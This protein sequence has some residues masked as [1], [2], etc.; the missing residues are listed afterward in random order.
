MDRSIPESASEE[1]ELYMRTYYSLLR[2]SGEIQIKS[3]IET[4]AQ[5]DSSLHL[6]AREDQPDIAAFVYCTLRLP[7]CIDRVRLVLLGQSDEV[8]VKA[9]FADVSKWQEVSA[10]GRRRKLFFDGTDVL[11]AFIASAS[12]IDDLI[13]ILTAH[14]IEWNKIHDLL[15][16][17]GGAVR[18]A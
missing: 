2:S 7:S 10:A 9:G 3:L 15:T 1:I 11:A 13:P 14:E 12:D 6:H 5:M 8:F 16:Q 18:L 4:H 17:S